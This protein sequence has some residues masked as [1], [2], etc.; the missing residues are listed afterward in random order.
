MIQSETDFAFE[1]SV[2][3]YVQRIMTDHSEFI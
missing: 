3:I 2:F 1:G